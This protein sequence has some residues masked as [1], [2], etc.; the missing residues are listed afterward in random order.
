MILAIYCC[1]GQGREVLSLANWI[2]EVDNRWN[3]I[4]FVDDN[5]YC[6][7]PVKNKV[8]TFEQIKTKC[9]STDCEFVIASGS[10]IY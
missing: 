10:R 1:G 5:Q 3:G 9:N 2:N 6:S 8:L 4:V 7:F